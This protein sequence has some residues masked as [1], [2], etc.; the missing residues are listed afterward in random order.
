MLKISIIDNLC[1]AFNTC[2]ITN[3]KIALLPN[4]KHLTVFKL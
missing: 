4:K 3:Y 1:K 2:K